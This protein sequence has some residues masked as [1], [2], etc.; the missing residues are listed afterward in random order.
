MNI[1]FFWICVFD[2]GC[3]YCFFSFPSIQVLLRVLKLVFLTFLAAG[4]AIKALL[5]PVFSA[6]W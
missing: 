4:D 1:P 5:C 6:Q 3:T 2:A